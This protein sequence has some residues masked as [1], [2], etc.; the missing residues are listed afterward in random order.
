MSRPLNNPDMTVDDPYDDYDKN[1]GDFVYARDMKYLVKSEDEPSVLLYYEETVL[2]T[3]PVWVEAEWVIT[4]QG[5]NWRTAFG[6]LGTHDA[7]KAWAPLPK[8]KE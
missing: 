7:P 3:G 4:D 5:G 1:V 2:K 6:Y 8:S